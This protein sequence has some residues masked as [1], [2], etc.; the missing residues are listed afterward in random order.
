MTEERARAA[1]DPYDFSLVLGGPIYQLLKRSHLSG[2][3]LELVVRRIVVFVFLAWVP[4]ALISMAEHGFAGESVKVP[5]VKDVTVHAR[6]LVAMPLL[7]VAELIVHQRMRT[8][9]R[10]FVARDL[11]PEDSRARFEAIVASAMRLRNS[12]VIELVVFAAVVV[13]G[14]AI[15]Q[16]ASGIAEPTW[17]GTSAGGELVLTKAGTWY[18]YVSI[19][20]FQVLAFRWYF[21]IVIW[22]RFLWQVSRLPLRIVPTHPDQLGGLAFLADSVHAFSPLLAAHGAL[23]AGSLASRHFNAGANVLDHRYE[24]LCWLVGLLVIIVGPMLVFSPR[25]AAAKREGRREYGELALRYARAFD[26]KWLRGGAPADETL[27]GSGD[28]Q[29]LADLGASFERVREMRTVPVTRAAVTQLALAFLVPIL[30]LAL[31]LVSL[32]ELLQQLMKVV[33]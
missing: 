19:T 16:A 28:I 18:A 11:V 5:F 25:L 21:R 33:L 17:Y 26:T 8:I 3:A 13:G 29:S 22:M 6:Y 10:Q 27:L 9:V 30:P 15:W 12:V 1:E 20:L 24:V 7:I 4:L 31:T 2:N 23:L 14:R 32:D